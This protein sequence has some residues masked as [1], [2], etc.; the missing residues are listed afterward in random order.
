MNK[1]NEKIENS[2]KIKKLNV[3]NKNYFEKFE[4][5][6]QYLWNFKNRSK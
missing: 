6:V 1:K 4:M 3:L 5:I 2:E